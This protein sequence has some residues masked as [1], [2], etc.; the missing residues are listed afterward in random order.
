MLSYK[1]IDAEK[2]Y[3]IIMNEIIENGFQ[4]RFNYKINK[5]Y[6]SRLS[7]LPVRSLSHREF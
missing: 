6:V 7:S 3:K 5:Q 1:N 2:A 4:Q